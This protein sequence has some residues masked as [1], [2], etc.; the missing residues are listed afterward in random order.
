MNWIEALSL[1]QN[2]SLQ[3]QNNSYV[4]VTILEVRGSS[5]RESGT[6]MVITRK[7]AFDTIGGGALEFEVVNTARQLLNSGDK[8]LVYESSTQEFNLGKDLKQCCGGVVKVLFEVFQPNGFN[9]VIFGAGHIGKSLVK[10]LEEI[11][12]SVKWFDSRTD[13]FPEIVAPNIQ[14]I[15]LEKPEMAVESSLENSYFLIMTHD[16]ALDQQLCEAI[17]SR[18]KS[19]YCGLIGSVTKRHKFK[20]RLLKKGFSEEELKRL[21]CPMGLSSIKTKKPMEIAVSVIATLLVLKTN[22]ANK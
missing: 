18:K 5:P 12:C 7:T 4:L 13:L 6:K 10:I 11:D 8:T 14:K 19:N 20:Q 3:N 17:L 1:L 2:Q 21:S 15:R 22:T 9:I 16:H